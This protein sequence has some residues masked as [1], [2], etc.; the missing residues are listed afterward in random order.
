MTA[1]Q[2]PGRYSKDGGVYCTLTDGN[3]TLITKVTQS[4]GKTTQLPG[5]KAPDGSTNITLTDGNG[6]LV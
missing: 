5:T 3:G 4:L 6:N 1:K 2:L